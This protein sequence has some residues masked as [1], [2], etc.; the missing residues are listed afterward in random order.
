M[1]PRWL[2]WRDLDQGSSYLHL[3]VYYNY[4]GLDSSG[5]AAMAFQWLIIGAAEPIASFHRDPRPA[6]A[7]GQLAIVR[8]GVALIAAL[9]SA[10]QLM[11]RRNI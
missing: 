6:P 1:I 9:S 3:G 7:V 11:I 5:A 8:A 4:R 10:T 2:S